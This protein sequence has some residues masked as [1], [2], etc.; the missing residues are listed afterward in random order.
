[1][2]KWATTN[3]LFSSLLARQLITT[4]IEDGWVSTGSI[5]NVSRIGCIIENYLFMSL[6]SVGPAS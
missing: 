6:K 1:M 5:Y 2:G 4:S 3:N